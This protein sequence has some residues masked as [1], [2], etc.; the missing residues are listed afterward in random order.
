MLT[1]AALE[2]KIDRLN[3][4]KENVIIGKLIPA[5]TGLKRYRRIEIEPSEPLPRAIDDVGLLD[6][7]E[8][9][10]ELGLSVGD[11]LDGGYGQEFD[12][13]LAS[14]EKIGA[15]GTDPGFAE[16]LAELEIPERTSARSSRQRASTKL[17]RRGA[18]PFAPP[19]VY[20]W[21]WAHRGLTRRSLLGAAGGSLAALARVPRALGAPRTAPLRPA[22]GRRGE[23]PAAAGSAARTAPSG[24]SAR[25]SAPSPSRARPTCWRWG[26]SDPAAGPSG[27][28][29][30]DP[31]RR[32]EPLGLRRRRR[33]RGRG[34][35]PRPGVR[36]GA[37]VDR[38]HEAVQL[39]S[40]HALA[41]GAAVHGR[42]QRRSRR[43]TRSP[44]RAAA[45]ERR[46]GAAGRAGARRRA[47]A[48]ADHRPRVLGPGALPAEPGA[49]LRGRGTRLRA[50]HRQPQRLLPRRG[51]RRCC[52][53]S[54][55]STARSAAG[56]TSATTS[57]STASGASSRRAPAASTRRSSAPTPAATTL[58]HRRGGARH[59]QQHADLPR[60]PHRPWSSCWRGSSRCTASRVL[61]HVVVTR[62]PGGGRLQP[63]PGRQRSLA[64]AHRG[65]PRRRH[66][67]LPG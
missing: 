14:L 7:D 59:L 64:A 44:P 15:G 29:L 58:L 37:A 22:A 47:G 42:R 46:R 61:G 49:R 17:S 2:G 4:L 13:D 11:E 21:R 65:T 55:C 18:R 45:D 31:R 5:A 63:L 28:P 39:R 38:G 12:A 40:A 34:R 52:G 10:A 24:C 48:A 19:G 35:A 30:P 20:S 27:A 6:Q 41:R 33:P 51:A 66:H 16:E 8:I 1:D 60:R 26:G 43:R 25:A 67:R 32:L 54:T 62:R 23:R 3:G 53:R 57:R 9:A 36:R 56:T 50:P